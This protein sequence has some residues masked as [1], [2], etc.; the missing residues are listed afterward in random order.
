MERERVGTSAMIGCH[1]VVLT[2]ACCHREKDKVTELSPT[3][4]ILHFTLYR[5]S[6]PHIVFSHPI[7]TLMHAHTHTHTHT[8]I[9]ILEFHVFAF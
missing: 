3:K 8:R 5:F 6:S 9:Y 4:T 1:L 2:S 7:L